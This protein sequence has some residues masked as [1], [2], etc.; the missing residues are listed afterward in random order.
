[1]WHLTEKHGVDH[2]VEVGGPGTLGRS[3]NSVT[4]G[5]QIALIGVLTGFGAPDAS[6]FP[7][8]ARNVRLDGIYVGSRADFEALNGFI[9]AK[10]MHPVIDRV[11]PFAEAPAAFAHLRSAAH[12]GKVVVAL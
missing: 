6:L 5:G 9:G 2:V 7:L 4:C 11:F 10:A 1:V 12:F 8:V 3:M